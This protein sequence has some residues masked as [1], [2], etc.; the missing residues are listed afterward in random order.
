MHDE[1]SAARRWTRRRTLGTLGAVGA[2]AGCV[3][4]SSLRRSKPKTDDPSPGT[5]SAD[6][7]PCFGCDNRNSGTAGAARGPGRTADVEWTFD[8]GTPT[9]NSSPVV[10]EN[11]VY[12]A[13]TGDP[14]G[15]CAVDATTGD[16][17]W[18]FETE[19]YVSSAPAVADG[20]LYAG[21]WG[22]TFYA[23]DVADGT[24]RWKVDVGHRF[25]SSSPVVADGTVVVGANGDGPLVVSGPE[26]EEE[27]EA[28]AVL[29]LDAETGEEVW[30]YDEFGERENV[31]SSPAVASGRVHVGGG[32]NLYA[33]DAETGSEIWTRNVAASARASPAVR[34]GLVYYAGPYRGG[35]APSR[36]WALDAA[37]GE[38]RW[39]YDLADTAQK[40]SPAVADGTVYVPAASQRVCLAAGDSDDCSGVTRG[41]LYAVDAETGTERWTAEIR[42]DTRSSPAVADGIV[43]VGCANG[44]SA[45][46]VDGAGAWRI[47]FEGEREDGPYVD[48]S[49]A[50]AGGRVFVGA[51]DG[52]LRAIGN[53]A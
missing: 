17:L 37:S 47:D 39:T 42:P 6:S 4:S 49:P 11:V 26:D 28:C 45:V 53:R 16:S 50:V 9:M 12:A 8:G 10:V 20:V 7:W 18:R 27:F 22:K 15:I 36:L 24:Q 52:R 3:T 23:V 41:R 34:D 19:G 5:Q 29:A 1:T 38:T 51:S 25:G 31:D 32:E 13:G 33:L 2:L 40:V 46:T 44:I 43:Y 30:R 21:T 35:D 14:G 48:S